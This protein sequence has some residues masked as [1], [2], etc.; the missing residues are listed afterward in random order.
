MLWMF[1]SFLIGSDGSIFEG[2]GW[3]TAPEPFP[4]NKWEFLHQLNIRACFVGMLG[5]NEG[6]W[7]YF[8]F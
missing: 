6:K 1:Y 5:E 3:Y 4:R 2:R 8:P 7:S